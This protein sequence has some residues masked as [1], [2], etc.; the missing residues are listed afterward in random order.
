ME[1]F[2]K[3]IKQENVWRIRVLDAIITAKLV[4]GLETLTLLESDERKIDFIYYK[5]LRK[6]LNIHQTHTP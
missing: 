4:Y 6:I 1:G 2:F 3:K 5:G